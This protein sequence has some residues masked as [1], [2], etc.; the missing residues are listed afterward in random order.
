MIWYIS[1][2]YMNMFSSL[3]SPKMFHWMTSFWSSP[4]W[5]ISLRTG[6]YQP[7][8]KTN[9]CARANWTH[10]K[11]KISIQNRSQVNIKVTFI[12]SRSGFEALSFCWRRISSTLPLSSVFFHYELVLLLVLLFDMIDLFVV[13]FL[14]W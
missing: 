12:R 6:L 5:L 11:K 10:V 3:I 7:K 8:H 4:Y 9:E 1:Y 13:Y 14:V 2:W